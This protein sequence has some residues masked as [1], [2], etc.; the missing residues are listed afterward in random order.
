MLNI[1]E[2]INAIPNWLGVD[3]SKQG[4]IKSFH[5]WYRQLFHAIGG[6][7]LALLGIW[8]WGLT[9]ATYIML[10]LIMSWHEVENRRN[11]QS[12]A[13]TV[14]DFCMW[15]ASFIIVTKVLS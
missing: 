14:I 5:F 12:K 1:L 9:L 7:L 10:V 3:K 11:G 13:K 4:D 2:F 8:H 15:L 6:A